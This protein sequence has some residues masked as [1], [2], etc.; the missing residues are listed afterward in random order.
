MEE[1]EKQEN[2]PL[3]RSAVNHADGLWEAPQGQQEAESYNRKY[4]CNTAVTRGQERCEWLPV[5]V[6]K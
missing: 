5:M 4:F 6:L 2:F 3:S 1:V